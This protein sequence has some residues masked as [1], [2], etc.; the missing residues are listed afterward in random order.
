MKRLLLT[1]IS[2]LSISLLGALPLG[3]LNVTALNIAASD[4]WSAS[5]WFAIAVI[6]VE[7]V[8]VRFMLF[9]A[10][11]ITWNDKWSIFLFP[12][13]S[14]LLM[15]LG[16]IELMTIN[17]V[18]S[19]NS[20]SNLMPAI[21]SPFLLGLVLSSINP[22]Q[23]PYWMGWNKIMLEKGKLIYTHRSISFYIAG[24]GI[25][26]FTAMLIFI[27]IGHLFAQYLNTYQFIISIAL[28][29]IYIAF[30]VYLAYL[31]FKKCYQ[32]IYV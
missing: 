25:G 29:L 26:T 9:A 13:A 32:L 23:F 8:V 3:T 31:F 7:M 21:S 10:H 20:V 24:I 4:S 15:Y 17:N 22:L 14:I 30:S 18:G 16:V 19:I 11:K 6:I 27:T 1:L 28:A 5:I 12:L 2:G